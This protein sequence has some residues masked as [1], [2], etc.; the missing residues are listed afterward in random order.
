[1][2]RHLLY[3]SAT[4]VAATGVLFRTFHRI[5]VMQYVAELPHN[6]FIQKHF[7]S[8]GS[9]S[10]FLLGLAVAGSFLAF[11][12]H[13]KGAVKIEE[14]EPWAPLNEGGPEHSA[15]TLMEVDETHVVRR[16]ILMKK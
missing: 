16:R 11:S 8:L 15:E 7:A 12:K 4:L 2:K 13:E 5:E 10:G 1:M 14:S 6:H 3:L 9:A